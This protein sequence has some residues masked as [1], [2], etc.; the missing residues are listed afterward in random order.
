MAA[1]LLCVF[2][3]S[4]YVSFTYTGFPYPHVFCSPFTPVLYFQFSIPS[5]LFSNYSSSSSFPFHFTVDPVLAAEVA[6]FVDCV[7]LTADQVRSRSISRGV[8]ELCSGCCC[9]CTLYYTLSPHGHQYPFCPPHI[10]LHPLPPTHAHTY[11][12][13]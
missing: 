9:T 4:L 5:S 6:T 10:Y 1:P 2:T 11:P 3:Y 13:S 8:M 7:K 12:T